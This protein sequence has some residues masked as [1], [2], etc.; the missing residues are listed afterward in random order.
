MS[1]LERLLVRAAR[2]AA[3]HRR[4]VGE[5]SVT[6][7]RS[8]EHI[9]AAFA[10]PLPEGPTDPDDV[11]TKLLQAADGAITGTAG[12]RY[13]G[14]V[15]G[16]ALPAA[17]AAEVLTTGSREVTTRGCTSTGR[18]VCGPLPARGMST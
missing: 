14:V 15:I 17:S 9:R 4:T 5:R 2:A 7:S 13:F 10:G 6:P 18:S 16:G 12:P 3:E 11:L 1:D 8:P